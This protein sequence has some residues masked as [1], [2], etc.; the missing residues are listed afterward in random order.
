VLEHPFQE[1]ADYTAIALHNMGYAYANRE[2]WNGAINLYERALAIWREQGDDPEAL[3][4]II[5]SLGHALARVGET[6]KGIRYLEEA[7]AAITPLNRPGLEAT[8]WDRVAWTYYDVGDVTKAIDAYGRALPLRRSAGDRDGEATTLSGLALT[9]RHLGEYRRALP[10]LQEALRIREVLPDQD[11]TGILNN[12]ALT[13]LDLGDV[14]TAVRYLERVR[15]LEQGSLTEQATTLNN[16]GLALADT[17]D[18]GRARDYYRR[19]LRLWQ[20]ARNRRGLATALSNLAVAEIELHDLPAAMK[21]LL[22][23]QRIQRSID[24]V[25]GLAITLNNIGLALHDTFQPARALPYYSEAEAIHEA[26]NQRSEQIT[27]LIN[28]A[29]LHKRIQDLDAARTLLQR[30][31]DLE[32]QVGSPRLQEHVELLERWS[33]T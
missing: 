15:E 14:P 30:V 2:D 11:L 4:A 12:L 31:I 1:D 21:H 7:L 5:L 24:D 13:W 32:R 26:T 18:F 33:R 16:I 10:L 29:K 3:T 17:G 19:A 25:A 27:T 23:A 6:Q 9:Y 20:T 8:I 22:R 28:R